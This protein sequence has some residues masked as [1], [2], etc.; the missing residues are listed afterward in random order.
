MTINRRK[1]IQSSLLTGAGLL[2]MPIKSFSY[3]SATSHIGVHPFILQNPDAVFIMKTNVDVKTNAA[4][5]KSAGLNF[6][7]SV[8]VGTNNASEGY[9]I[10]HKVVIKPNLTCRNSG[11][12]GYTIEK[13]MGIVT[14]A[15]FVEGIIER[16][17]ELGV[18]ANQFY[19]RE[20]NCASDLADG[21][22]VDMAARTGIDCQAIGTHA[23]DLQP[24]QVVWKDVTN[25]VWFKK[26]PYL[27]PVN[28]PDTWLLNISKF[29]A[30]GM[31]MTL[32]AKN[33]QGT[34]AM[35]YQAHCTSYGDI[36]PGVDKAHL[37]SGAN[38]TIQ[39][40]Y[41]RHVADGI[42]RWDRPDD[43]GGLWMETWAS[44]CLDNNS[45]TMAG[46]HII[47]GV[48]GRDGNFLT[49]PHSGTIDGGEANDFM[50]N[51]IIFGKNQ[52]H[53]DN[54]GHYLAGHEPGNFGLFHLAK[55]RGMAKTVNPNNIPLFNWD[56]AASLPVSA[57]LSSFTRE[58]PL[59]TYYLQR[60]YDGQTEEKWHMVNEYFD[61]GPVDVRETIGESHD[62]S[63][64]QI[65]PN[66]IQ[67]N[68]KIN[69]TIPRNGHV[70]VEIV[71]KMGQVI[72]VLVNQELNSG[73]HTVN[74]NGSNYPSDLYICRM[75]FGGSAETR[76]MVVLH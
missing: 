26:I 14:D 9:P 58:F 57:E 69:F 59:V 35:D 46:L 70:S 7:K 40:N 76:K 3:P 18:A 62:F 11:T 25:G 56:P 71:N 4:A 12:A 75:Q 48:Y 16:I 53:V 47:E 29:K 38:T 42:P 33:L 8:F 74:W 44:R 43:G 13:S 52:F 22:Y 50:T 10:T 63:L 24:S 73:T 39:N 19:I 6:G 51:F 61:Y 23:L 64:Q 17:K 54:I 37:V 5:L 72:D 49:G 34:I 28:A 36:M 65:Y 32:C 21:G 31:G 55:E 30:H 66:P 2:A 20:V 60:D 41:D 15:H 1:F 68:T 27:W 67:T 45:V